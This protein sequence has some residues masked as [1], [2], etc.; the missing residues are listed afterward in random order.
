[1]IGGRDRFGR[2]FCVVFTIF[3]CWEATWI[4]QPQLEGKL[5]GGGGG[6]KIE[7]GEM[8]VIYIIS[9]IR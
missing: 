5:G 8:G 2:W 7:R 1:M 3:V 6:G 4:C 9:M